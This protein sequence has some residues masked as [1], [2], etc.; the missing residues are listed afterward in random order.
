MIMADQQNSVHDFYRDTLDILEEGTIPVLIGG[1]FAQE[2]YTGISRDTKDLDL[3]IKESDLERALDALS[4]CGYRTEI[5]FSHWLGKAFDND[6]KQFVDIIFNSGNG[7]CKVDDTWFENSPEGKVFDR[8]VRFCPVEESI[9]QKAFI[10]ERERYDGAD[11]AHLF[12]AQGDKLDW[13]RLLRRFDDHW[14]VLMSY[15]TLFGYIYPTERSKI[16]DW[17][18]R[19]LASLFSREIARDDPGDPVCAGTFLSRAQYTVDVAE[20]GYRDMRT[21]DHMTQEAVERWTAAA[22]EERKS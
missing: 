18:Q 22:G 7:L 5:T 21:P 6:G 1:A 15:I 17:V 4:R 12:R 8:P 2:F 13:R 10:M 20:W 19:K 3:F 16:P 14:R 11:I 9:W